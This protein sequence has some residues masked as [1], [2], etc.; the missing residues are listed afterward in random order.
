MI[1][2]YEFRMSSNCSGRVRTKEVCFLCLNPSR[3]QLIHYEIITNQSSCGLS[4][5]RQVCLY[6]HVPVSGKG[7]EPALTS[8][9]CH[10][11]T[12]RDKDVFA[13]GFTCIHLFSAADESRDALSF[14]G[15]SLRQ[16]PS[17][18]HRLSAAACG[19]NCPYQNHDLQNDLRL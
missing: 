15:K 13:S 17:F 8:W 16:P 12:S 2:N 10:Y 7:S 5:L 11:L 1:M 4:C 19:A 6:I 9:E 18:S 14:L 3:H